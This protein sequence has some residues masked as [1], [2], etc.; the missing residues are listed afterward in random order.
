[1]NHVKRALNISFEH[2]LLLGL[3]VLLLCTYMQ[4]AEV[5]LLTKAALDDYPDSPNLLYVTVYVELQSQGQASASDGQ[6]YA[7]TVEAL[8]EDQTNVEISE[9]SEK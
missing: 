9:Q 7:V 2:V 5:L 3:L 8:N 6:K 4:Q 1:M